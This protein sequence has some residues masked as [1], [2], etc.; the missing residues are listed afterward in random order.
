MT[1]TTFIADGSSGNTKN[2]VIYNGY[3]Q[4]IRATNYYISTNSVCNNNPNYLG[5][6]TKVNNNLTLTYATLSD[7]GY[8]LTGPGNRVMV[9]LT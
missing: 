7:N 5:G 3:N 9:H 6:N 2:N 4:T 8:L 1:V